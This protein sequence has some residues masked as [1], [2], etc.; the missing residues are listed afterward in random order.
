MSVGDVEALARFDAPIFGAARPAIFAALLDKS[1]GRA[2]IAR[3]ADG[4]ISSYLF[5]Q[6]QTLGPWA[7]RT[8][9]DAEALLAA[10]LLLPFQG[11]PSVL[12]PGVN[13]DAAKLLMRYGFSPQRSLRRMRR[14]GDDHPGRRALLY[15][16]ASLA[17]G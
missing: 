10:A 1:P 12:V 8:P 14:G 17:I 15:G 2:F 9:A 4:Q 11:A 3:D 7:A 13:A 6:E 16:Q 5:A